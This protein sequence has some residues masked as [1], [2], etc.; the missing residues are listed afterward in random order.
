VLAGSSVSAG[1]LGPTP[2]QFSATS[3]PPA[4]GRHTV[5]VGSRS[6]AGQL[7]LT[8]VHVSAGSH[9]P[10]LPLQTV[11]TLA[12]VSAGH[13]AVL[14]VQ[15]SATS[16]A[17]ADGRH[18]VVAGTNAFAGHA[19]PEPSQLSATSQKPALA[20]QRTPALMGRQR[21][22][23]WFVNAFEQ[24]WQFVGLS[25]SQAFSQHTVSTHAPLEHMRSRSQAVPCP[26]GDSHLLFVVLQ[27]EPTAQSVSWLQL[28]EHT[29][30]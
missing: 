9:A 3:Q 8:P 15:F 29:V 4:D 30:P 7:A 26:S 28:P 27:Y 1:Q 19:V 5:V 2:V 25:L 18:T 6:F 10:A 23:A 16:H 11:T 24:A 12:S 21:P 14:H 17:P 20:R 13:V 22:F